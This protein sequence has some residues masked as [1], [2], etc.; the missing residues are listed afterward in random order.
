[1]VESALV[2]LTFMV[3]LFGLMDFGRM[4]WNYTM[5][6]HGAREATRYAMVRGSSSS[7]PA[8]TSQIQAIVTS[9]SPGLDPNSTTSTVTF[10]PDQSAGSTVKVVV[11]YNFYAIAPYI[12]VGQ[13]TLRSTSQRVILQ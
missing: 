1:M 3:V 11:S 7:N 12:P 5:I 6:S 4:V 10:T 9:Q 2:L 8:T 13:I